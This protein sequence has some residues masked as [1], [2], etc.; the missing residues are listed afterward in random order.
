[1][2][3]GRDPLTNGELEFIRQWIIAGA[4]KDGIVV[5]IALLADTTRLREPKVFRPLGPPVRGIYM[6]L[7]PFPVQ[8]K[9]EREFNY[10]EPNPNTDTVYINRVEISMRPGS[11]HFIL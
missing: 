4:P 5:D 2:P 7:G 11:H 3:I 6:K 1:M 10:Y 8:P 9:F